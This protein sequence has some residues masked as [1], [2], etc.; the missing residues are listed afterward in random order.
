MTAD[1]DPSPLSDGDLQAVL[2]D[3]TAA[4]TAG[5]NAEAVELFIRAGAGSRNRDVLQANIGAQL[6]DLGMFHEATECFAHADL[7]KVA[8]PRILHA[9]TLCMWVRDQRDPDKTEVFE[10]LRRLIRTQPQE[11]R[12]YHLGAMIMLNKRRFFDAAVMA[13][14][15]HTSLDSISAVQKLALLLEHGAERFDFELDGQT[16]AMHL[17]VATTQT[18]E[19]SICHAGGRLTEIEELRAIKAAI[20]PGG[21]VCEIGVLLGNHT[22]YFLRNLRPRR[23]LALEADPLMIPGI[24]KVMAW[25]NVADT[26]VEVRNRFISDG[27][28]TMEF[29]GVEVPKSSLDVEITEPVDFLKIDVD[30]AEVDLLHAAERVLATHRPAMMIEV[31]LVTEATCKDWLTARGFVQEQRISHGHYANLLFR[32][33]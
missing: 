32:P 26:E 28:G 18:V 9:H 29:G 11:R 7:N 6:S 2:N 30:G 33:A 20:P 4:L 25:N 21:S 17:N 10:A 3:A 14:A 23:L 24:E 27:P 15:A 22:A 19:G 1:G 31:N 13:A 12:H 8:N 16:Y 5:R